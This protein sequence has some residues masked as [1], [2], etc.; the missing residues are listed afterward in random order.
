METASSNL[1]TEGPIDQKSATEVVVPGD[2]IEDPPVLFDER[3]RCVAHK[4]NG[5][6]CRRAAIRGGKVCRFHGGSAPQVVARA[7]VRLQMQTEKAADE[8][9]AMAM[10]RGLDYKRPDVR[11]KAI[12]E[13]LDRGGVGVREEIDVNVDPKPFEN[14]L[15]KIAGIATMT[16]DESRKARGEIIDAEVVEEPGQEGSSEATSEDPAVLPGLPDDGSTSGID[17]PWQSKL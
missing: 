2:L 17:K 12:T 16:R 7:R 3:Y 4:K 14:L 1:S 6:R 8:L 10:D 13:V 15:D 9:V 11:L 5:F